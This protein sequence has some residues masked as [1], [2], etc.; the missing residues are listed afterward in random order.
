[1]VKEKV[2]ILFNNLREGKIMDLVFTYKAIIAS[3]RGKEPI[4]V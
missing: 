1:M 4:R 2:G 3:R